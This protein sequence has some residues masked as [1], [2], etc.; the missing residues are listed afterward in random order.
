MLRVYSDT[1]TTHKLSTYNETAIKDTE[2]KHVVP[3]VKFVKSEWGYPSFW[4]P[5]LL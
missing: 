2:K 3:V 5:N 1:A 4:L